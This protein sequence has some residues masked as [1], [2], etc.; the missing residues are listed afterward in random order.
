MSF[1]AN[2]NLQITCN[3]YVN[4]TTQAR[5]TTCIHPVCNN[6]S[7]YKGSSSMLFPSQDESS[8]T[9]D[10]VPADLCCR[11]SKL[12]SVWSLS[13]SV[14]KSNPRPAP[15]WLYKSSSHWAVRLGFDSER[16]GG[17]TLAEGSGSGSPSLAFLWGDTGASWEVDGELVGFCLSSEAWST[18]PSFCCSSMIFCR[19][20]PWASILSCN[21]LCTWNIWKGDAKSFCAI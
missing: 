18:P 6:N 12:P 8:D 2:W 11:C 14:G 16:G 21:C 19:Y 7:I 15:A 17:A 5:V 1:L 9:L 3:T 4:Q 20:F 13:S 10:V